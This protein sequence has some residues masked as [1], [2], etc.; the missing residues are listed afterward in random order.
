M[1]RAERVVHTTR[2]PGQRRGFTLPEVLVAVLLT[3][4]LVVGARQIAE[5]L[6][7]SG[8]QLRRATAESDRDANA[9]RLLRAVV[10]SYEPEPDGRADFEGGTQ[11][12][13][14][15]GWCATPAGWSEPCAIALALEPLDDADAGLALRARLTTA[16]GTETLELGT[17]RPDAAFAYLVDAGDG[18]QWV[19]TWASLSR[20]PIAVSV[21]FGAT[22]LLV[23]IGERG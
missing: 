19:P 9:E 4:L 12:M 8:G 16:D 11:A 10:A 5:Q 13:H 2:G 23:V 21:P 17:A 14:F 1:R 22:T 15:G 6:G 20:A 3:A 7:R 18:G